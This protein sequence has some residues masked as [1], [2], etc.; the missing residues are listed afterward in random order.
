MKRVTFYIDGFNFYYGLRTAKQVDEKWYNAYWVDLVKFFSLFLGEGQVLEKVIYFTA[1][2]LNKEKSRHQSAFLFY[3]LS[4]FLL[5][6]RKK[7]VILH[8]YV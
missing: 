2:P 8:K 6:K 1:S 4:P 3:P 7:F 5:K